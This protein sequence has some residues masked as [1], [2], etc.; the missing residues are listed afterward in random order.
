MDVCIAI[1]KIKT[2][3]EKMPD[4]KCKPNAMSLADRMKKYEEVTTELNLVPNLPI[5]ARIDM[6]A[7]H[8]FCKNLDK[9]FDSDYS[10][11]MK[12]AT[13]YIVEKAGAL[14]GYCQSD[15]ASFVWSDSTKI[16]FETRLFK[17]QSVLASM[18]TSA[19]FNACLDTKLESR[20]RRI[21]ISSFPSFDCR[22][23][24]MP[25][26]DECAN[27]IL[28]RER[29]SIKNSI[30]LLSLEHFSNAA[31]HKKN[32]D[33]KVQMLKDIGIDYYS[34]VSESDRNGT[35]FRRELYTKKLDENEL[36]SIPEANRPENGEVVRSHVVEFSLGAKLGDIE[37]KT[38]A[39]FKKEPP[40]FK[41][42]L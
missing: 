1:G 35:Y 34:A 12:A 19:F 6:R 26:L 4:K 29:D 37:N 2:R 15:E 11:A 27:M 14:L 36:S 38:M 17:L 16:P 41:K 24:N 28:W 7:G 18:F 23:C 5:Y 39:L 13:S 8:S 32:S 21:T 31:I 9:P 42:K 25:S 40:I 33:E 20:A 30:T 22:V 3:T 10:S